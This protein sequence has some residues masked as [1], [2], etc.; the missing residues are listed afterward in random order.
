M[1]DKSKKQPADKNKKKLSPAAK[2]LEK[3][4]TLWRF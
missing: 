4:R 2:K 1:A 3:T